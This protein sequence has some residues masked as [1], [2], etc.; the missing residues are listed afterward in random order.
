MIG[1][2]GALSFTEMDILGM[3]LDA[4]DGSGEDADAAG[5]GSPM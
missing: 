4:K 1:G 2:G 5:A 3:S